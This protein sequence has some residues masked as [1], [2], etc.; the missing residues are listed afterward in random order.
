MKSLLEEEE[1]G[2]QAPAITGWRGKQMA[3]SG[4]PKLVRLESESREMGVEM[5]GRVGAPAL[6]SSIKIFP[7]CGPKKAGWVGGGGD[8]RGQVERSHII[9]AQS[10]IL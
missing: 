9:K 4:V 7:G 8:G 3:H 6:W 1:G 2:F 10:S 5:G